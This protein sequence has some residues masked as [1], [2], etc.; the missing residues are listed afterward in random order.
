MDAGQN[1]VW[2][3][4][5]KSSPFPPKA[6]VFTSRSLPWWWWNPRRSMMDST[7]LCQ[8]LIWWGATCIGCETSKQNF[9]Q[10]HDDVSR[11]RRHCALCECESHRIHLKLWVSK[12]GYSTDMWWN[13]QY[14]N[15]K[16]KLHSRT[17]REAQTTK[18]NKKNEIR[19]GLKMSPNVCFNPLKLLKGLIFTL[20]QPEEIW[21]CNF[22]L[23]YFVQTMYILQ[24][25]LVLHCCTFC[26]CDLRT[27]KLHKV[28]NENWPCSFFI[29]VRH[30]ICYHCAEI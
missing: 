12:L 10:G 17:S 30:I 14:G 24:G 8:L 16:W 2:L 7:F 21:L 9:H 3:L 5:S 26:P 20:V 18:K 13:P 27:C 11:W 29:I 1:I 19:Y 23:C 28:V 6:L 25:S 22:L 4:I 15:M